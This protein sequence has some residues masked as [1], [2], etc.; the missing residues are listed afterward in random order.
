MQILRGSS[1]DRR[2]YNCIRQVLQ[3]GPSVDVAF[4][5]LCLDCGD[6][7][8]ERLSIAVQA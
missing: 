6:R 4:S 7:F 2:A 1:D 5:L 3:Y 8:T